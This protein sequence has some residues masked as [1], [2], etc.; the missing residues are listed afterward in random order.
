MQ[1]A[2]SAAVVLL[3]LSVAATDPAETET[4][5]PLS[6]KFEQFQQ[7]VQTFVSRVEEKAKTAYH[8]FQNSEFRNRTSNW[9]SD[10]FQKLKAKWKEVFSNQGSD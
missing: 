8:D 1:V 9:F 5:S 10:T 4:E 2:V 7:D 6:Q 3:A